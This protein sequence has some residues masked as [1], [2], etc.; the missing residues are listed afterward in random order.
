MAMDKLDL[1]YIFNPGSIAVVGVSSDLTKFNAGR[2]YMQGLVNFGYKGKVYPVSPSGGEISGLTIYRNVKDIPN[3]VDYVIAV[4]PAKYAPKLVVDCAAKGVKAIHFYTAGFSEIE[5]QE[6]KKLESETLRT[7]RR[8]NIRLIG[9][10]CMGIYC[11]DT[12]LTF[13]SEQEL[14]KQGGP[15][16]F[17]SQSGQNSVQCIQEGASRGVYFSKAISYG[18]ASDL[19]E[20]DFLEYFTYDSGTEIIVA[21]LEGV[22]DSPRFRRVLK[23]AM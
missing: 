23:K 11:P 12:S 13:S 20:S 6:G 17:F 21:Y 18:N 4:I 7:A 16:G 1:D 10:N 19:N 14:P 3:K 2:A 9:P 15:L 5:D 22:K 8:N